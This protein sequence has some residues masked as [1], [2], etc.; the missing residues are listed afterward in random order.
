MTF[1]QILRTRRGILIALLLALIGAGLLVLSGRRPNTP[2]HAYLPPVVPTVP[3]GSMPT[4]EHEV[5]TPTAT[6]E[7]TLE[8][9]P[10]PDATWIQLQQAIFSGD[11][12]AGERAWDALQGAERAETR[13]VQMAG[14]R[15][16]LLGQDLD[17]AQVR[18]L[19]AVELMGT[20]PMEETPTD[21]AYA[22][23]LLG[24]VLHRRGDYAAS[25]EA[26]ATARDLDP[27]IELNLLPDRWRN[28]VRAGDTSTM[29]LLAGSYS[30]HNP[31]SVWESYYRASALLADQ[32]P[33]LAFGVLLPALR[34]RPDAP[35][36]VWYTLGDIYVAL[37][38]FR[39]AATVLEVVATKVARGDHSLSVVSDT[40]LEDLDL[41]L[42]R[43]YLATER[44]A[45]AEGLYRRLAAS[46]PEVAA[47]L[48]QAV[49]CQ[50]PTPT[51]T[52]WI[53][54]LQTPA[55]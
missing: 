52:P 42:A 3:W 23:S 5:V 33:L 38:G 2:V 18:A 40:P 22:W 44:C 1:G 39:E 19:R 13:E 46:H 37:G 27:G 34:A 9:V 49:I 48:Q 41:R 15:L 8:P 50:T 25:E 54:R 35:A 26:F 29:A 30:V 28:A 55:P 47:A 43:A 21:S 20:D 12:A 6:P 16:A 17:A 36:L 7:P 32:E 10:T 31:E 14:A 24:V 11:L 45:E 53:L 4:R 51:P